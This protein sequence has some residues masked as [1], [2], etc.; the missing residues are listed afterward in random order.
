MVIE[1]IN[2]ISGEHFDDFLQLTD[3]EEKSSKTK[4]E[5]LKTHHILKNSLFSSLGYTPS[6]GL[7]PRG[8][9]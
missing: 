7:F 3:P 6:R 9:V 4:N 2:P 5:R 8:G 1:N